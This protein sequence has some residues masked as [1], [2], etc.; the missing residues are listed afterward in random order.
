MIE[1]M[2]QE[3][4]KKSF[5]DRY[6][7]WYDLEIQ[8][9][10]RKAYR[11]IAH[12]FQGVL[13]ADMD[14]LEVATGTGLFALKAAPLV[15]TLVATDYSPKMIETANKKRKP[16]NLSFTVEDAMALSFADESFDAV[17]IANALH[18]IPDPD[19]ALAEIRRVLKP[20]GLLLAPNFTHGHLVDKPGSFNVR[21][22]KR[23]GF[24]TYH[25]W[26]P[27]EYVDFIAANGFKIV[28]WKVMKAAF[29]LVYLT[30]VKT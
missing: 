18:I 1:K 15:S 7:K 3:N 6:A 25:K 13:K 12:L 27:V 10:S 23:L 30:A 11:Q 24:E 17:L 2:T 5:W 29:P 4:E 20:T 21:L 28:D 26:L 19:K 9:T 8:L 16:L 14:M 22:L